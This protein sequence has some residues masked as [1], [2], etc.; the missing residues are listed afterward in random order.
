MLSPHNVSLVRNILREHNREEVLKAHGLRASD[1]LLLCGPPGCG[2]TFTAEVIAGELGRPLAMVRNGSVVSSFLGETGGRTLARYRLPGAGWDL[3]NT[4]VENA[5]LS[6]WYETGDLRLLRAPDVSVFR[7][8][9][10]RSQ[11][12]RRSPTIPMSSQ[13]GEK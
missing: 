13:I 5:G 12:C 9:T 2:K 7:P 8:G 6:R 10:L 1:R 4:E 3:T 11:R